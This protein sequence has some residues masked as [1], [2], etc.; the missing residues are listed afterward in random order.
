MNTGRIRRT[1]NAGRRRDVLRLPRKKVS[2]SVIRPAYAAWRQEQ[3]LPNRCDNTACR[4]FH[5]ELEWNGKPLPVILDHVDGNRFDNSPTNLRY[6][7][8]NCDAQL[9]T[10][11]GGN[12]G[13]VLSVCDDGCILVNKD[14][15]RIAAATSRADGK[16]YVQA[17]GE[18]V[19]SRI[20]PPNKGMHP[21]A[22][23]PGGG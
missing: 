14:G 8:P 23:K 10:R 4:F 9:E 22:Q 11:G 1:T 17:I 13:R 21:A 5:A 3:G 2:N 19:H 18:A 12:R 20:S 16:S 7:C 15:T 6:L